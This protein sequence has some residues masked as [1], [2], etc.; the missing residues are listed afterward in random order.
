MDYNHTQQRTKPHKS[1]FILISSSH[2]NINTNTTTKT[3]YKEKLIKSKSQYMQ[4][5]VLDINHKLEILTNLNIPDGTLL[6]IQT[7]NKLSTHT[8]QYLS[9]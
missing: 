4:T 8:N 5:N 7:I 2:I 3:F 6:I 1:Q 9:I